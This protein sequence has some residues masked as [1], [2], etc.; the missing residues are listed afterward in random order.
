LVYTTKKRNG[1]GHGVKKER[2]K[3]VGKK[4]VNSI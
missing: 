3:K 2:G 4:K 1:M